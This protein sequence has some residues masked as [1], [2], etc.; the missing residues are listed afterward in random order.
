[1]LLSNTLK[2][3]LVPYNAHNVCIFDLVGFKHQKQKEKH[4]C[5]T[6]QRQDTDH[7]STSAR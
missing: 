3:L 2:P 4:C 1:M 5:G 7:L 6:K